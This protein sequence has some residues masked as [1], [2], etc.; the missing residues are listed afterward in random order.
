MISGGITSAKLGALKQNL[1][2]SGNAQ[3]KRDCEGAIDATQTSQPGLS[4]TDADQPIYDAVG[5][6]CLVDQRTTVNEFTA[7]CVTYVLKNKDKYTNGIEKQAAYTTGPKKAPLLPKPKLDLTAAASGLKTAADNKTSVLDLFKKAGEAGGGGGVTQRSAG[8]GASGGGTGGQL[9]MSPVAGATT[10]APANQTTSQQPAQ[11]GS[12]GEVGIS[13]VAAP[14]AAT[15]QKPSDPTRSFEVEV[16]PDDQKNGVNLAGSLSGT[17]GEG[18]N[19]SWG[20][21][22]KGSWERGPVF[23]A[24]SDAALRKA[25]DG[26]DN[27]TSLF[28]SLKG[29]YALDGD[30][31]PQIPDD[32]FIE[33]NNVARNLEEKFRARWGEEAA[34]I[35][36]ESVLRPH[37]VEKIE[38]WQSVVADGA[39][40]YENFLKEA[41]LSEADS[42]ILE[43]LFKYN[44]AGWSAAK[45]LKT[46]YKF[47]TGYEAKEDPAK[48]AKP[49]AAYLSLGY[50]SKLE[51]MEAKVAQSTGLSEEDLKKIATD[52]NIPYPF[53]R[54]HPSSNPWIAQHRWNAYRR[55]LSEKMKKA[56]WSLTGEFGNLDRK[57]AAPGFGIK[58]GIKWSPKESIITAVSAWLYVG[59]ANS[60][61]IPIDEQKGTFA[62]GGMGWSFGMDTDLKLA[63]W[64]DVNGGLYYTTAGADM[65]GMPNLLGVSVIPKL[66]KKNVD[67][68]DLEISPSYKARTDM[69]SGALRQFYELEG[70]ATYTLKGGHAVYLDLRGSWYEGRGGGGDHLLVTGRGNDLND[71]ASGGD[72]LSDPIGL[73][74]GQ[75]GSE[76]C[77]RLG[78]THKDHWFMEVGLLKATNYDFLSNGDQTSLFGD[79]SNAQTASRLLPLLKAGMKF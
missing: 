60:S 48:T 45:A 74:V 67:G 1:C 56:E 42:K 49:E 50:D 58:P 16:I 27:S 55:L 38:N 18:K 6:F 77:A 41:S 59:T 53:D 33:T 30:T 20:W 28:F 43:T 47:P 24:S 44:P 46:A 75:N 64:L 4:N 72:P 15:A 3:K 39:K 78:F 63:E 36:L 22:V 5:K 31:D 29:E 69:V 13:Q 10:S 57:Y 66:S 40:L 26:G 23:P 79:A 9:I 2:A 52:A 76:L 21:D 37:L 54:A 68:F 51:E 14:G 32:N 17:I 71:Y 8:T 61:I 11:A 7:D 12:S 19:Y 25:N 65:K 35:Y 34:N 70:R 62:E 73:G